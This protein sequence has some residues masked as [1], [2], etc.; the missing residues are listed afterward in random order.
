MNPELCVLCKGGK[1]LCGRGFCE[2]L[3]KVRSHTPK[4]SMK[5][6]SLFGAS[7]PSVFVG[8]HDYPNVNIGPLVPANP[9]EEKSE[10]AF[11]EMPKLW[12]NKSIE[13]IIGLRSNL[14]LS[15]KKQQ[16]SSA[17]LPRGY[18]ATLQELA[19]S[20]K[21][22]DVE[23]SFEK[24]MELKFASRLDNRFPPMGPTVSAKRTTVC[25]NPHVRRKVDYLVGDTDARATDSL[26]ELYHSKVPAQ[27]I[28][29][30]FSV[31]LMGRERYRKLVPTR[32]SI[33]AVD[34]TLSKQLAEQIK[35]Y[36]QVTDVSLFQ[37]ELLGNHFYVILIPDIHSFDMV[38]TWVKGA[39]WS[40]KTTTLSDW[41]DHNGRKK[42]ADKVTGAYYAARLSVCEYLYKKRKQAGIL[43][44]REIHP[45]YYAP[46]G[47]WIIREGV[48]R[49]F[50]KKPQTFSNVD[51][52]VAAVNAEVIQKKWAQHSMLLKERREQKKIFDFF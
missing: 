25:E 50:Y 17:S 5:V 20:Y 12:F 30:L 19:I 21:P 3:S 29:R 33:T 1:D 6:D 11:L 38:E 49:S 2:L 42:Y 45:E 51:E 14:V 13:D 36:P 40:Y 7:P 16:V 31:G 4:K 43:V 28:T 37:S 27:E 41:E 10:A 35:D 32:W 24:K 22:L 34:D 39:F 44:Y 46:L 15:R 23:L 52:A 26:K 47:V 18:L 8:R 48:A 9:F